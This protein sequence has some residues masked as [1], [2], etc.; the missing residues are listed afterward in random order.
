PIAGQ[1]TNTLANLAQIAGPIGMAA[2]MFLSGIMGAIASGFSSPVY[3]EHRDEAINSI[4]ELLPVIVDALPHIRTEQDFE[5]LRHAVNSL[6][7][8]W[9]LNSG[10]I[11]GGYESGGQIGSQFN[12]LF[13][14]A[15]PLLEQQGP[16]GPGQ[17]SFHDW[18]DQYVLDRMAREANVTPATNIEGP[19]TGGTFAPAPFNKTGVAPTVAAVLGLSPETQA[20]NRAHRPDLIALPNQHPTSP[21]EVAFRQKPT[22]EMPNIL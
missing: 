16:V 22:P 3:A 13:T 10:G 2:G 14:Q 1:I 19:E 5:E 18:F 21:V 7:V 12:P 20:Y 9:T 6:A 11:T 8:R 4:Q 17:R 15:L